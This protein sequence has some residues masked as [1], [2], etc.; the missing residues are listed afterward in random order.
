MK[1]IPSATFITLE[2]SL[3]NARYS[4]VT[5]WPGAFFKKGKGYDKDSH[6]H[7]F[8]SVNAMKIVDVLRVSLP[9]LPYLSMCLALAVWSSLLRAQEKA[10][11]RDWADQRLAYRDGIEFWLDLEKQGAAWRAAHHKPLITGQPIDVIYDASGWNRDA[12]QDQESSLP[13]IENFAGKRILH[14]DGTDD[15]LRANMGQSYNEL[16]IFAVVSANKNLGLF[17]SIFSAAKHSHNDYV[18]GTNIDLGPLPTTSWETL[19]IEGA[20][21]PGAYDFTEGNIPFEKF[22]LIELRISKESIR[23]WIDGNEQKSRGRNAEP[24]IWDSL[25]LGC[26]YYSNDAKPSRVSGF[27]DGSIAEII[28]YGRALDEVSQNGVREYLLSKHR[29]LLTGTKEELSMHPLETL[30]KTPD[31]QIL[32]PGFRVRKLPLQLTNINNLRYRDDGKLIAL[33]YNGNVFVLSDTDGDGLEDTSQ[34]F[35]NNNGRLRG[36]LGMHVTTRDYSRGSGVIVASKGKVSFLHDRNRDDVADEEQVIA[37]GWKEITQNVD[38]LGIA[39]GPD[40]SIYFGLGTTNYAN[41]Y[42]LDNKGVA[43]FD[44]ASERGNILRILP[45]WKSRESISKGV[46]FPVALDFNRDGELFATD[47]EGATWLSNGNPFDE[48]L[49]IQRDRY[50]GFPPS[51]PK[52]LPN[53]VDEPS[54]FDYGPQHQSTCGL[55]FNRSVGGGPTFGPA[56]WSHSAFVCGESRGKIFRT[57]LERTSSGYV[58]TNSVF[59]CLNQLTVDCCVTPKGGLLVACHSGPPDWG[60]GPEG[61]GSIY[62]IEYVEPQLPQPVWQW[63]SGPS[64]LSIAFDRE[65]SD[66]YLGQLSKSIRL[67]SGRYNAAGDRFETLAPPYSVVQMQRESLRRDLPLHGIS[68]TSDRRTIKLATDRLNLSERVSILLPSMTG[69]KRPMPHEIEQVSGMDLSCDMRGVLA[70]WS[71]ASGVEERSI[72][73]PHFESK[74]YR[75]WT[76]GSA[77]H[78]QFLAGLRESGRLRLAC[79]IDTTHLLQPRIQEG[80]RLDYTPQIEKGVLHVDAPANTV[81]EKV[82]W[83]GKEAAVNSGKVSIDLLPV[84]RT[85]LLEI[86]LKT[87]ASVS[88]ELSLSFTTVR[89]SIPRS[90]AVQRMRPPFLSDR[91]VEGNKEAIATVEAWDSKILPGAWLRGREIYYGV[92]LCSRC[93]TLRGMPGGEVGPDL[94]NLAFKDDSSILRDIRQPSATL[95]PDHLTMLVRFLDGEVVT[96]VPL[97]NENKSTLLLGLVDGT[98]RELPRDEIEE[99]KLSSIS[100]MPTG[101]VDTLTAEDLSDLLVFLKRNPLEPSEVVRDDQPSYRSWSDFQAV[102]VASQAFKNPAFAKPMRIVLCDGPKDHGQDEHDYPQWKMRWRRLLGLVKNITVGEASEW[103]SRDQWET[104]DL[105]VFYSANPQWRKEKADDIDRFLSRGGGLVFMHFAVNG[106]QDV[107]PLALRIGLACDTKTLK[108]RHGPISLKLSADH[109]LTEGLPTLELVDESYWKMIGDPSHIHWVASGEEES[110]SQPLIWTVQRGKGRVFV[111]ILGHYSWTLDDPLYRILLLRGMMWA[112][113]QP[114]DALLPLAT[115]GARIL[116]KP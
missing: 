40:E 18:T 116:E 19:N 16:T 114:A 67:E 62:L 85:P 43:N 3:E 65:L 71:N 30:P 66:G 47:Q 76:L 77:E 5:L 48:L 90:L 84:D 100:L 1:T 9:C 13:R 113:H 110:T 22:H 33:A 25:W 21:F 54:V 8:F 41:G 6:G 4:G 20:G 94:T 49:H 108:F 51:H 55:F 63:S 10:A 106:Q 99:M 24:M 91:E 29:A 59:A 87:G 72:L 44:L 81:I 45:D 96:G 38:A 46:R 50:Y 60:T 105:I 35:W 64:E 14:F 57:D 11:V 70:T 88:T 69:Q 93:H 82:F 61:P 12:R 23:V 32:V 27:W 80:A 83:N 95:N 37:S 74:L 111:S 36:P 78:E 2:S 42:L 104:A 68:L 31:V 28:V 103:P 109:P 92:G 89:D 112:G 52:H 34:I 115:V 53:V 73:L 101:L 86:E 97:A 39:V 102:P 56:H 17:R 79:N 58:A 98:R 7:F 15:F 26:R 75:E 107:D